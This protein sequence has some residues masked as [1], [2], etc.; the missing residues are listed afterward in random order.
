MSTGNQSNAYDD[1]LVTENRL[2]VG[3]IVCR[4]NDNTEGRLKA[5]PFIKKYRERY[6]IAGV[7]EKISRDGAGAT[8]K[9]ATAGSEV[10]VTSISSRGVPIECDVDCP[11]FTWDGSHYFAIERKGG[12]DND[13]QPDHTGKLVVLGTSTL[14]DGWVG[15]KLVGGIILVEVLTAPFY[16]ARFSYIGAV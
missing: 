15:T 3:R 8:N 5:M 14:P 2:D 9:I 16:L 12:S 6:A 11:G 1:M 4:L 7:V 13:Y 10:T